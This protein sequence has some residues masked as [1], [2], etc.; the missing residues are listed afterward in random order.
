MG[1]PSRSLVE[2][3]R[4][5]PLQLRWCDVDN[6][7]PQETPKSLRGVSARRSTPWS[8]RMKV[9]RLSEQTLDARGR[10]SHVRMW[11]CREWIDE[12]LEARS[13]C[14]PLNERVPS[15]RQ[16]GNSLQISPGDAQQPRQVATALRPP[17]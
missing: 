15:S 3:L 12:F 7:E 5:E 9:A 6:E 17:T 1:I 16:R 2:R 4:R 8:H 10:L 14:A 13:G 11:F